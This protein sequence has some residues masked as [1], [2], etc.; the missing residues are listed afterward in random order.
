MAA[1]IDVHEAI[2]C[3]LK[4]L[5]PTIQRKTGQHVFENTDKKTYRSIKH[6]QI[7]VVFVL[8]EMPFARGRQT[9]MATI[10]LAQ[11]VPSPFLPFLPPVHEDTVPN[12]HRTVQLVH[13]VRHSRRCSCTTTRKTLPVDF[14]QYKF[15]HR[16]LVDESDYSTGSY[17]HAVYR[18]AI[19]KPQYGQHRRFLYANNE[20]SE[21]RFQSIS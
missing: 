5:I 12:P 17:R 16:R 2:P 18:S 8:F 4:N 20:T 7:L 21:V 9:T 1:P 6:F 19:S 14:A 3:T 13:I 11:A 10:L 15:S